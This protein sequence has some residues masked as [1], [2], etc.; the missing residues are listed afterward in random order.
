[1]NT[2]I[3]VIILMYG[4]TVAIAIPL[5]RYIGKLYEGEGTRLDRF[6]NQL[7]KMFFK[8]GY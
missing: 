7:E 8:P 1:M 2:E 6:L 4:L 3:L 5:G